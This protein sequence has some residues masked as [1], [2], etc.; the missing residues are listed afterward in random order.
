MTPRLPKQHLVSETLLRR[1]TVEGQLSVVQFL[2]DGRPM[3]RS[4]G[5]GG[6]AYERGLTSRFT[7]DEIE[8]AWSD[9]ETLAG[10]VL[11]ELREGI[12]LDDPDTVQAI[13]DLMCLHL[14]RSYEMLDVWERVKSEND[15]VRQ[16]DELIEDDDVMRR[17]FFEQHGLH[18]VGSKGLDR[19]REEWRQWQE[20]E[21]KRGFS[22]RLVKMYHRTKRYIADTGLEVLNTVQGNELIIGDCPAFTISADG[23]K[24]GLDDGVSM[25]EA[26]NI[27]MP[28]GPYTLAALGQQTR[29]LTLTPAMTEKF[30]LIQCRRARK[31]IVCRPGSGL[32]DWIVQRYWDQNRQ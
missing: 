31:Q 18:V 15:V 19:Y 13:K 7:I 23:A 24:I 22:E 29:S 16:L 17:A 4:V 9:I 25:D 32:D 26:A 10:R 20:A 30:N 3:V 27:V 11:Q 21:L 2:H 1:W 14:T 8:N 28:L 12:G 6:V 5:P